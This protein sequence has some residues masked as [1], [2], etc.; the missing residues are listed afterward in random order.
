MEWFSNKDPQKQLMY[1]ATEYWAEI[2]EL[3][4]DE[5]AMAKT[6]LAAADLELI[7]NHLKTLGIKFNFEDAERKREMREQDFFNQAPEDKM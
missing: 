1:K 4:F 2:N 5:P 7:E 6:R 3:Y